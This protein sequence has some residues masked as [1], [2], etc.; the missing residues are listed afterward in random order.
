MANP[1]DRLLTDLLNVLDAVDQACAH[2]QAVEAEMAEAAASES[3]A[4]LPQADLPGASPATP[5]AL[6]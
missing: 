3:V 1:Y 6:N 4:K 5:P 2:W